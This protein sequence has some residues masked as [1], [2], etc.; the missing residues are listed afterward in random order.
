MPIGSTREIKGTTECTGAVHS[1][2][3]F[4]EENWLGAFGFHSGPLC[5]GAI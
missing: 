2:V 4:C 3:Y 1:E 5:I